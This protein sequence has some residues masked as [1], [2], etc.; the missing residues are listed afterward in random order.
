MLPPSNM[1]DRLAWDACFTSIHPMKCTTTILTFYSRNL[2]EERGRKI[3]SGVRR[4]REK[5]RKVG[6]MNTDTALGI[7]VITVHPLGF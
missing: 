3:E 4:Q 1:S 5:G 2:D 6:V 7:F